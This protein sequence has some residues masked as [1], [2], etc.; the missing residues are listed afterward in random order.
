MRNKIQSGS[1]CFCLENDYSL[2]NSTIMIRGNHQ[3]R[4][5]YINIVSRKEKKKRKSIES[6]LRAL[7]KLSNLLCVN[8]FVFT[9]V[10]FKKKE[11]FIQ[12]LLTI[13]FDKLQKAATC[14]KMFFLVNCRSNCKFTELHRSVITLNLKWPRFSFFAIQRATC[15]SRNWTV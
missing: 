6:V 7:R 14:V 3:S 2:I 8:F 1:A 4:C 11:A 9:K 5:K 15:N 10:T 12:D 13:L